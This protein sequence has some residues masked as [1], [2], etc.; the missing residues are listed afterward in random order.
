MP[1]DCAT[2]YDQRYVDTLFKCWSGSAFCVQIKVNV[3]TRA[4]SDILF[5]SVLPTLCQQSV[6]FP[7]ST[8]QW[9]MCTKSVSVRVLTSTPSN[10][11]GVDWSTS[12]EPGLITQC[13]CLTS[14]HALAANPMQPGSNMWWKTWNQKSGIGRY[15]STLMHMVSESHMRG[16]FR[17]P[18][19]LSYSVKSM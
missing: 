11:F 13:Q 5:N 12:C 10:I 2:Q 9:P 1:C 6:L 8:W 19:T 15:S 17:C 16:M 14:P 18:H 7:V 4:Y 3:K